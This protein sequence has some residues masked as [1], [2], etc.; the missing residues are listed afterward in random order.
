MSICGCMDT[1][2]RFAD[3]W[4]VTTAPYSI[5]A[6]FMAPLPN[7]RRAIK[8]LGIY[9]GTVNFLMMFQFAFAGLVFLTTA[10]GSCTLVDPSAEDDE[11]GQPAP[12]WYFMLFALCQFSLVVPAGYIPY[13]FFSRMY[14]GLERGELLNHMCRTLGHTFMS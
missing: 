8:A 5:W 10:L 11:G 3:G 7:D 9:F 1:V 2:T 13:Q 4:F 12:C 14:R 6:M